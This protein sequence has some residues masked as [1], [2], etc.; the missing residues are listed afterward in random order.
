MNKWS[1]VHI[2]RSKINLHLIPACSQATL[3]HKKAQVPSHVQHVKQ[4]SLKC[5]GFWLQSGR[6]VRG[7]GYTMTRLYRHSR[8]VEVWLQS[9]CN[10]ALKKSTMFWPLYSQDSIPTPS[11]PKPSCYTNY[12]IPANGRWVPTFWRYILSP[13]SGIRIAGTKRPNCA[14]S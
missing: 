13:C 12:A 10:L 9:I 5:A 8:K 6:W 3:I 14:T 2:T 7:K 4:L 1:E 11:S